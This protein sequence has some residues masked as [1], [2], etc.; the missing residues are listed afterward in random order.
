MKVVLL[1]AACL[2]SWAM[3][4]IAVS[5]LVHHRVQRRDY[6]HRIDYPLCVT[7]HNGPI[8]RPDHYSTHPYAPKWSDA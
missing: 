2:L 3:W 7:V 1:F 5:C 6:F 4:G 8:E